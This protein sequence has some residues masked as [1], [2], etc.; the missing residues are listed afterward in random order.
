MLKRNPKFQNPFQQS[1]ESL[2]A[3]PTFWGQNWNKLW[4]AKYNLNL[5]GV[6]SLANEW[7]WG[8]VRCMKVSYWKFFSLFFVIINFY[9]FLSLK[10]KKFYLRRQIMKREANSFLKLHSRGGNLAACG[11]FCIK[12]VPQL[13]SPPWKINTV[14][15]LQVNL[16]ACYL[17]RGRKKKNLAEKCL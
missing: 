14:G 8:K 12:M 6:K 11:A 1:N 9:Q 5:A 4:N 3:T 15:I 13:V 2:S 17:S 7:R 10:K 16:V